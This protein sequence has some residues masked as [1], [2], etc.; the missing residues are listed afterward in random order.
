MTNHRYIYSCMVGDE[1][2]EQEVNGGECFA[3]L[4]EKLH[5]IN[6]AA[7]LDDRQQL[8]DDEY[9][10]IIKELAEVYIAWYKSTFKE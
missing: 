10:T 3:E 1:I 2:I 4:Q 6:I 7:V 9:D 5:Y 8:T